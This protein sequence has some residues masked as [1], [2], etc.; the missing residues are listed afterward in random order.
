MSIVH[1]VYDFMRCLPMIATRFAAGAVPLLSATAQG[2]N[3]MT[4]DSRTIIVYADYR[5]LMW[6]KKSF[7]FDRAKVVY[8][9]GTETHD[10]ERVAQSR[11]CWWLTTRTS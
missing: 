7:R 8:S 10:G 11:G 3:P 9:G 2:N 1:R 4:C 5:R 6:F